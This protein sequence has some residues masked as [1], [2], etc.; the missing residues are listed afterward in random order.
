MKN[1]YFLIALLIYATAM[2]GQAPNLA[3]ANQYGNNGV[4]DAVILTL[5]D[6]GNSY[7]SGAYGNSG[8]TLGAF[9]LSGADQSAYIAKSSPSGVV[10]WAKRVTK[11]GGSQD[12]I[13][14]EKIAVD[15]LGNV[16]FAGY[17]HT[18]ATIDE[19]VLSGGYN[20]FLTKFDS[21]GVVG[22]T[23]TTSS[24]YELN[25]SFN[26][27]HV[28]KQNN[29]CMVGLYQASMSFNDTDTLTAVDSSTVGAQG[30][31]VKYNT[32]GNIVFAT[33]IGQ[34]DSLK[35]VS[36]GSP[37]NE[38]FQFDEND[39][40]YRF[41]DTL[42]T[43]YSPTGF[44]LFQHII[45]ADSGDLNI[46]SFA[47]DLN[48]NIFFSGQFTFGPLVFMGDTLNSAF[49]PSYLDPIIIKLD[50]NGTKKWIYHHIPP[51]YSDRTYWTKL[52]VDGIGNSYAIGSELSSTYFNRI[53]MLK[54]NAQGNVLWDN[55]IFPNNPPLYTIMGGIGPR[56]IVQAR[57]GGNIL[58][59][60]AFTKYIEFNSTVNFTTPVNVFRIFLAQFG[61]CTN[62]TVPSISNSSF[63]FCQGDSLLLT[64]SASSSYLWNTGDT[65]QSIYVNNTGNYYVF[66]IENNECYVQSNVTQINMLASPNLNVT[67]NGET[68][69]ADED[70]A[71]YQWINCNDNT[72]ISGEINQSYTAIANGNYAV[73]ITSANGC[74]DTSACF[75]ITAVGISESDLQN[76]ISISPNPANDI[77]NLKVNSSML[78][79]TYRMIETTGRV[80]LTGKI[81][82]E[83]SEI[84]ISNLSK[85]IYFL[86]ILINGKR[87]TL[88]I[89]KQ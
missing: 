55:S 58:A 46:V 47:V 9:T 11:T 45:K 50:S 52:R 89:V 85:G 69:S 75:A 21:S 86:E 83:N 54:L 88:K 5:D 82:S 57:N 53:M 87:Q 63:E 30:F 35:N 34:V 42:F 7:M 56:N 79:S 4:A 51:S 74:S 18:G 1:F 2:Q 38:M 67:Q 62:T 26:S 12:E 14:P 80:I 76:A 39:N 61:N 66:G 68:L 84:D 8:I 25:F 48:G 10:L 32:A 49:D 41:A 40:I 44:Q 27:I 19:V 23:K 24:P 73:I 77:I 20:Y 36:S 43:K 3:W 37:N 81:A 28:D 31:L 70:G 22:W 29:L 15:T 78:G 33:N 72:A 60:G 13:N 59:L 65:T 17:Y 64:A 16:Y 71:T 6:F